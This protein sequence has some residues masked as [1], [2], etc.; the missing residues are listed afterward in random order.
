[1]N[2]NTIATWQVNRGDCMLFTDFDKATGYTWQRD[3]KMLLRNSFAEVNE[4]NGV[5]VL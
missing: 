2:A 3:M 5:D 1:L 4:S